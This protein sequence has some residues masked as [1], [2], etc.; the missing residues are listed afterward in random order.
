MSVLNLRPLSLVILL[1]VTVFRSDALGD[2]VY[3]LDSGDKLKVTVY[4]EKSLSGKFEVSGEG[5]VS[6]PLIGVV[7]AKGASIREMEERITSKLIDGYLKNPRVS[8]EVLNYRPFYILGEVQEPG[9]YPYVN[10]MTILNAVALGGGYTYRANK[11]K[12]TLI[13][14]GDPS[15]DGTKVGPET[16]VLPGDVVRVEERFF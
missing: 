11:N 8:I 14:A 16:R 10:G 2:V 13:R 7:D 12:I 3:R 9:S 4:E 6:L 1:L 5:V 15:R